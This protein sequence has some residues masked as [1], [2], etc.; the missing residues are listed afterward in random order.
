M[1]HSRQAGQATGGRAKEKRR[2]DRAFSAAL[3][4]A[5]PKGLHLKVNDF[6]SEGDRIAV[7]EKSISH[8][9]NGRTYQNR[10]H[11]MFNIRS[12]KI[13]KVS[14]YCDTLNVKET[15]LDA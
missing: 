8:V 9:A 11:F 12:G 1:G 10:Y 14:G 15:F 4:D 6:I 7:E 3:L 13:S 2:V 5:I